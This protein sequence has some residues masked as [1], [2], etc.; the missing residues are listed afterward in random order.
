MFALNIRSNFG[1]TI[2]ANRINGKPKRV[3]WRDEQHLGDRAR[4]LDATAPAAT[5]AEVPRQLDSPE[6]LASQLR[7]DCTQEEFARARHLDIGGSRPT[8]AAERGRGGKVLLSDRRVPVY[9]WFTE[10]FDMREI[11]KEAKALLDELNA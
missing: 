8:G 2:D 5:G 1:D 4:S 3:T 6:A 10:G 9:G 11:L 7:G